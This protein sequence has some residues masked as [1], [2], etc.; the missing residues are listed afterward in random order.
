MV[1]RVKQ[2]RLR[3]ELLASFPSDLAYTIFSFTEFP[4]VNFE[5]DSDVSL[6]SVPMPLQRAV[7]KIMRSELHKWMAS[8]VVAP[9]CW[10]PCTGGS[11][12]RVGTVRRS[13]RSARCCR[14][15][16]PRGR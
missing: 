15:T 1:V 13:S 14:R 10:P 3:G 11:A 2:L 5:V 4:E 7:A 12:R 9:G 16:R 6:G 8:R